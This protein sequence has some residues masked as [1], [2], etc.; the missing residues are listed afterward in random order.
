MKK[1]NTT[2]DIKVGDIVSFACNGRGRGGHYRVKAEVTKINRKT[3]EATEA[4]GSY[5][6]GCLWKVSLTNTNV[7]FY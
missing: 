7:Y 2:Q 3:F 4:D 6:P 1:V 5:K